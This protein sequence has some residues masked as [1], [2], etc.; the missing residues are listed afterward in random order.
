MFDVKP[1]PSLRAASDSLSVTTREATGG[2]AARAPRGRDP[3][4]ATGAVR[5][6]PRQRQCTGLEADSIAGAAAL[7]ADWKRTE[8]HCATFE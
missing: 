7:A 5:R 6:A 2:A 4:D 1:V 3:P 8:A